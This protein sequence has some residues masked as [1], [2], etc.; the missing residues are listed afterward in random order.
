MMLVEK[1]EPS[2][3]QFDQQK[4]EIRQQL[5]QRKQ[6]ELFEVYIANLR[7]TAEKKGTVRIYEKEFTRM[8]ATG[9]E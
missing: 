1:Q 2:M 7:N 4:E 3:A 6:T 8:L 9:N 5:L